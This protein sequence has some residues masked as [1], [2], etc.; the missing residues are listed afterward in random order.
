MGD[1][2]RNARY[3]LFIYFVGSTTRHHGIKRFNLE[4]ACKGKYGFVS[5]HAANTFVLATFLL[6]LFRKRWTIL[7]LF[8]A[9]LVSYSR[10]YLGVHY[11]SDVA[12]GA[13][14]GMLLAFIVFRFYRQSE[15]FFH[16]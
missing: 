15:D 5:S 9:L 14:L 4:G 11:P 6:L 12:V 7:L 13:L 1:E 8:W 10:V 3:T 16:I 2:K